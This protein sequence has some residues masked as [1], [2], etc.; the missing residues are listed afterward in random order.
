ME[1]NLQEKERK[2][3]ENRM[4]RNHEA[5]EDGLITREEFLTRKNQLEQQMEQVRE[6][7]NESRLILLEEERREMPKEA[8]RLFCRISAWPYP[9]T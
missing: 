3:L 1:Q 4:S 8:V 2:K 9:V 5:Y 7:T 6:R